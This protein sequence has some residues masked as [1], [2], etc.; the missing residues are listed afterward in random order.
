MI[1]LV[2]TTQD[3]QVR[4]YYLLGMKRAAPYNREAALDAAMKLFWAKGYHATS[5]KDLEGALNMKP[6][7]IYAAFKSKDGLFRA[8]LEK[9][10]LSMRETFLSAVNQAE[11]PIQGLTGF[12]RHLSQTDPDDVNCA[13]CMLI[14]TL[15][16]VTADDGDVAEETRVY[17]D[18]MLSEFTAVFEQARTDGALR[19]DVD[20]ARLARRYQAN[21]VALQVEI[22]RRTSKAALARLADDMASELMLVAA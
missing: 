1:V 22:H 21:I 9:Y 8:A 15:L 17:L 7:S 13:A 5:L 10:F 16:G 2:P 19:A 11:T 6:G 4:G 20:C 3:K 12:M 14:K 18:K